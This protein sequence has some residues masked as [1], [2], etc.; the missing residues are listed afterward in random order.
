MELAGDADWIQLLGLLGAGL[1]LASFSMKTM[2]PLRATAIASNVAFVVYGATNDL[3]PI[4]VL[5]GL[6]LP[7]NIARLIQVRKLRRIIG[8]SFEDEF[9]IE[10]LMPFMLEMKRRRG[11]VLFNKGDPAEILF[12]LASG[13]VRIVEIGEVRPAGSFVGEIALFSPE[14]RRTATVVCETDCVFMAITARKVDE[15]YF[16]N[17]AFGL[18]VVRLITS[19]LI[20]NLA[21]AQA[22]GPV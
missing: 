13:S 15:L 3:L 10:P 16:E 17:P 22:S 4:V 5:N 18:Y 20:G 9:S 1:A 12:Y 21:R 14:R 8:R 6:S 7:I 19:R 2:L 11:F